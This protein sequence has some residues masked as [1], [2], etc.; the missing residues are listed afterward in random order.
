MYHRPTLSLFDMDLGRIIRLRYVQGRTTR[1]IAAVT[2]MAEATVRS[3]L[4]EAVSLLE[5]CLRDK[6]VLS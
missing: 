1:G 4:K 3:R 2:E 5:S 6:G